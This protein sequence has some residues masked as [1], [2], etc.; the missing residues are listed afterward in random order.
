MIS[1]GSE[2]RRVLREIQRARRSRYL[3]DHDWVDSLYKSYI[4]AIAMGLVIFYSSPIFAGPTVRGADLADVR[5]LGPAVLGV[6]LAI[7]ALLGMRSGTRGGPLAIEEPDIVHVL[8]APTNR[9]TVLRSVALRQAR[10]VLFLGAVTGAILGNLAALRLPG[11]T[12][13]WMAAGAAL[14]TLAS[15]LAWGSA[16]LTSGRRL[17]EH[18]RGGRSLAAFGLGLVAW[19]GLDVAR[20]SSTS[21]TSLIARLALLPVRS[22][23]STAL[24]AGVAIPILISALGLAVISGSSLESARHRARLIGQLRFAATTQDVRTVM[25]LHRQLAQEHPRSVPRWRISSTAAGRACWRRDWEGIARW[26]L[27]RYARILGIGI[28]TGFI[29]VGIRNGALALVLLAAGLVYLVGLDLA[30]GLAQET[31]HPERPASY[32]VRWGDL[33]LRHLLVPACGLVLVVLTASLV[34]LAATGS[35]AALGITAL[36]A[37][38]AALDAITTTMLAIVLAELGAVGGGVAWLR[39]RQMSFT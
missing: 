1:S 11:A 36:V 7:L 35:I 39:T 23:S 25:V 6:I 32:P 5:E 14:G 33:I 9:G 18:G 34:E 29:I 12:I 16:L 13:E 37:I 26:P 2:T 8:L 15:L 22:S 30:E 10:N 24:A 38:P 28:A 27:A 4:T 17:G 3:S 20:H 21:P 19:S 31:D